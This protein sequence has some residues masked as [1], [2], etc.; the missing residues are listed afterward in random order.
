MGNL[1]SDQRYESLQNYWT[2]RG[3]VMEVAIKKEKAKTVIEKIV[4][5]PTWVDKEP[6]V[7]RTYQHPEYGTVQSQDYQVFLAEN[8][9]P[10]GKYAKTVPETKRQRIETAYHEMNELL[11]IDWE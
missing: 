9:L 11:K 10:G 2:E 8:Y 1:I 5:H 6:I 3:V 7:G 4:A